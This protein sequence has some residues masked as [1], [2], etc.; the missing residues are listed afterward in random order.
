[1]SFLNLSAGNGTTTYPAWMCLTAACV[2]AVFLVVALILGIRLCIL[3]K[4]LREAGEE[5]REIREDLS[6]NQAV[7]LPAPDCDLELMLGEV[8]SCLRDIQEER[9]RYA[10]R[11]R[12]FQSQ[13][14]AVS[15][16]LRT[17]LT[18]ILGYL[19]ML[20]GREIK[21]EILDTLIRRAESMEKLTEQFYEYSRLGAG[22]YELECTVI[23]AGKILRET[24]ADH[25]MVLENAGLQVDAGFVSRPVPV[26][27]N[28]EALE[29]I[30]VNLIQNT[31]RYARSRVSI[32]VK[33]AEKTDAGDSRVEIIFENDT[34]K[35]T[36][37]DVSR[38]FER[39]YMSDASRNGGGTGLGLTVARMLA[40]KMGGNLLAE[41]RNEQNSPEK[42]RVIRFVLQMKSIF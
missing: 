20:K 34:E 17:P 6:R 26:Q 38:L 5:L 11:E 1:M 37:H 10:Q 30:L 2:A 4:S 7:R 29:R 33:E 19:R 15:H 27:G 24:F 21:R 12:I 42:G 39:F 28:Q 9:N 23:D 36:E 14:E 16:D 13:I 40:E 35:L 41:C 31:A 3:K 18:V 22:D 8:N 32:S 25:C